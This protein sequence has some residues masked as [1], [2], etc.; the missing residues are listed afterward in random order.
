MPFTLG[1]IILFTLGSAILIIINKLGRGEGLFFSVPNRFPKCYPKMFYSIPYCLDIVQ[2]SCT[3]VV[4]R[5]QKG[6]MPILLFMGM[7]AN[8]VCLYWA[9]VV[10]DGPLCGSL[11]FKNRRKNPWPSFISAFGPCGLLMPKF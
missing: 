8:G 4:K 3:Q 2:L 11:K 9:G 7:G 10:G 6:S 5:A 1:A